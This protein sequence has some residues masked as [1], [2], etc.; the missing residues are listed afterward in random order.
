MGLGR[1][2]PAIRSRDRTVGV[3][4]LADKASIG[5]GVKIGESVAEPGSDTVARC[6]GS[7]VERARGVNGRDGA[8]AFEPHA[9]P[10]RRRVAPFAVTQFFLAR[11][12]H[13][14]GLARFTR[15]QRRDRPQTGLVFAAE[16]PAHVRCN[17]AH[18]ILRQSENFGEL[19]AVAVNIAAGFPDR[20]PIRFPRCQAVARLQGKRAG[21]LRTVSLLDDE[22][23][24]LHTRID[25]A[26]R[27]FNRH[28]AREIA[29]A[30]NGRRSRFESALGI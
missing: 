7:G 17:H 14:H 9:N 3:G 19:F 27:K 25:I 26:A 23:C 8:V 13:A 4:D 5:T 15:E 24:V 18:L 20:E 1:A 30:T 6:I 12:A 16:P 21:R 29:T 28:F 11:V 2:E 10:G 22:I